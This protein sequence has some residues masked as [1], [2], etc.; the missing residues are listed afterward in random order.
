MTFD[1]RDPEGKVD[2]YTGVLATNND[3]VNLQDEWCFVANLLYLGHRP[4]VEEFMIVIPKPSGW[5]KLRVYWVQSK[6]E[7]KLFLHRFRTG[8]G[9]SHAFAF[10]YR[11]KFAPEVPSGGWGEVL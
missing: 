3:E 8:Q 10:K 7:L 5:K 2:R 4:P 1:F 11:T 6:R 9:V